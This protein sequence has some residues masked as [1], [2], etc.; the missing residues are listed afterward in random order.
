M[1]KYEF[2]QQLN[3]YFANGLRMN[4]LIDQDGCIVG[5]EVADASTGKKLGWKTK[6]ETISL[7]A[8]NSG[9]SSGQSTSGNKNAVAGSLVTIRGQW[10]GNISQTLGDMT[11]RA[12]YTLLDAQRKPP[13]ATP[14]IQSVFPSTTPPPKDPTPPPTSSEHIWLDGMLLRKPTA[15]K[16]SPSGS[17]HTSLTSHV[18]RQGLR[19]NIQSVQNQTKFNTTHRSTPSL[20]NVRSMITNPTHNLTALHEQ[21]LNALINARPNPYQTRQI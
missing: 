9:Y 13:C 6:V 12:I 3:V 5:S 19:P 21:R 16:R 1:P 7:L 15:T 18:S 11:I 20:S 2:E 14:S 4:V 8:S 17:G 10:D